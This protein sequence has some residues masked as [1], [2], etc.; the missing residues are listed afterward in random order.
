MLRKINDNLAK[1]E[2]IAIGI[3]MLAMTAL[4]FLQVLSRYVL[5]T[6]YPWLEEVVKF[7]MFWMTYLGVPLLIY[8]GGNINIDFIPGLIKKVFHIDI[9]PLINLIVLIFILVFLKETGVFLKTTAF[10]QQKSQVMAIPMTFVYSVFAIG[11][12]LAVFHSISNFIF[13]VQDWRK[14]K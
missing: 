5:K 9:T 4:A 7:M 14:Q 13:R 3:L 11:N 10:Y 2:S 8:K 6:S 1:G 12:I